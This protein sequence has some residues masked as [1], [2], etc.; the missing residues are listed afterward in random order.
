LILLW[1]FIV[2]HPKLPLGVLLWIQRKETQ[3]DHKQLSMVADKFQ[4]VFSESLLNACGKDAKF[5]RRQR[6]IT[7]FRLGLALTA[8]C[9]SHRVET[10]ADF[11]RGFH[12]LFDT[13]ITYKAFSN[14][15][16]KPHFAA[17]VGTLTSRLVGEMTLKVLGFEKGRACAAFRHIVMQD[18]S[19]FALHDALREVFPG[20]FKAVKPAAVELHTTMDV[21]C[22]APMTVV[23]TPDTANA[24]A[25]LPEPAS[26]RG[27]V[28]LA[29]RGSIDLHSLRRVQDEG[30]FLLIRAKAGMN[31]QVVEA[32]REDG[33]RLRSLRN[34]PFQTIHAKLPKRQR[35]ELVVRWQV[36]G[37]SL[38]L[39][40]IVSWN[41]HHK[42]F[43]SL[44]TNLPAPR[45]TLETICR[46]Y[47]WRWQVELLFKEWKSY[48]NLH[49]CATDNPAIVEGLMWAAIAAAALT[50]FLAHI[51]QLLVEVPMSTRKVAMCAVHVLGDIVEALKTGDVTGLSAALEAAITYLA[52]HAQRA[53]PARDRRTGRS[54]L[55]LEP[56]FGSDDVIEFAE[57]A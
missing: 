4:W 48:A 40:L 32:F 9:A 2:I 57:A 46:A 16:A 6:T 13:T 26:L 43:C 12:V 52:C 18:G 41:R 54:Q 21:L 1:I 11:H 37:H 28:L 55:G 8:T 47:T 50:R 23:L 5:C 49:A 31:P 25:F 39:R 42:T 35:V 29:D 15:V 17:F 24:Q 19:S 34:K 45:D 22:D 7:P 53:H 56:L 36:D 30:G 3:M 51:T 20:R 44:L 38:C 27:R 14:Q 10:L 33:K